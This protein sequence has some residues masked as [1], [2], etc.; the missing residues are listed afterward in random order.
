V[1]LLPDAGPARNTV[2][3]LGS[4]LPHTGKAAVKNHMLVQCLVNRVTVFPGIAMINL[5]PNEGLKIQ[6][7][8]VEQAQ[9]ERRASAQGTPQQVA[10]RCR[11]VLAALVGGDNVTIAQQQGVS[12]PTVQL[13]RKQVH[14][15]GIGEVWKIAPGRGRKPTYDQTKRDQ[16]IRATLHSKPEGMTHWSC[17]LMARAQRVSRSTV[18]RLWQLHNLKSH[19]NRTYKLSPNRTCSDG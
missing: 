17:R 13:W 14:A 1:S 2:G 7:Q 16:I 5:M 11:I 19:L 10:L 8:P 18:N 6:L 15:G 9:L 4:H 12:R 3:A